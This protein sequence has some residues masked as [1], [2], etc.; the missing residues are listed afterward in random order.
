MDVETR[1]ERLKLV[2]EWLRDPCG[3]KG[4]LLEALLDDLRLIE[5]DGGKP[6]LVRTGPRAY[7]LAVLAGEPP[8][9]RL[10]DETFKTPLEAERFLFG[11]RWA[12]HFGTTVDHV[13]ASG[14]D[15]G[16]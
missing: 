8:V 5:P 4:P 11:R 6:L 16:R 7:R 13:L 15:D 3:R 10:L 12:L 9:P 14:A 1:D 2:A